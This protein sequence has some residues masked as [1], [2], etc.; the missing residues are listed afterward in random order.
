MARILVE[1]ADCKARKPLS[2]K[3]CGGKFRYGPNKG[4][5]CKAS[6]RKQ[7]FPMYWIEYD[8]PAALDGSGRKP[9][10]NG[11]KSTR[12]RHRR[13]ERIGAS[14]KAAEQRLHEILIHIS[15]QRVIRRDRN[16]V[17]SLHEVIEWYLQ[18]GEIQALRSYGRYADDARNMLR[19]LP[20]LL[21]RDLRIHHLNQYRDVRLAE[22][23][24]RRKGKKTAPA[25]VSHELGFLRSVLRYASKHEYI[26]EVPVHGWPTIKVRNQRD[27]VL[28]AAEWEAL[29]ASLSPRLRPM[30]QLAWFC[31]MRQK[32][33]LRLEWGQ[34]DLVAGF[35]RLRDDQTKSGEGRSVY[36]CPEALEVLKKIPRHARCIHRV[37]VTTEGKGYDRFNGSLQR[38][39]AEALE[40]V[41]ITDFVFHD[42]RHCYV[43]RMRLAGF[44]DFL[45]QKQV[46]HAG[47][48]MT[49]RYT[50]VQELE[51]RRLGQV[52]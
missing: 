37:F 27:R 30:V 43:S 45:I 33:I 35:I 19:L 44:P 2:Q 34:V 22:S 15:E 51:L 10:K 50:S 8:L 42:L 4:E 13:W 31:G 48:E 11:A 21:V 3:V 23:S 24:L 9:Q 52:G 12:T 25:T 17:V 47:L 29:Q 14:L 16:S 18:Q 36:L 38:D 32:E 20:D 40:A 26:G 28:T 1:C 7:R 49:Q 39:W 6:L 46:G 5:R 41:G